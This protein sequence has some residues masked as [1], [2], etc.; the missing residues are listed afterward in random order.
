MFNCVMII[1]DTG[2]NDPESMINYQLFF[3]LKKKLLYC[4]VDET[5]Y[6]KQKKFTQFY[7]F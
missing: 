5:C 6:S 3:F 7:A 2:K 1:I 4:P